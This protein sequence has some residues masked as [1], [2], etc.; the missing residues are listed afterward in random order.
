MGQVTGRVRPNASGLGTIARVCKIIPPSP[1]PPAFSSRAPR[2]APSSTPPH[3]P[4]AAQGKCSA[5]ECTENADQQCSRCQTAAYCSVACQA[6]DWPTHK[7]ECKR[8]VAAAAAAAAAA[9][10]VMRTRACL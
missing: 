4:M 7:P 1:S 9:S 3:A 2:L 10:A 6:K 8:L 5:S